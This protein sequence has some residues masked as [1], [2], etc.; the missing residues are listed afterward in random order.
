MKLTETNLRNIIRNLIKEISS[1]KAHK[2]V[3]NSANE[4]IEM[5]RTGSRL[6]FTNI[7]KKEFNRI[8]NLKNINNNYYSV[9][10]N[11]N[12]IEVFDSN[13]EYIKL[14]RDNINEII[15][16]LHKLFINDK[17]ELYIN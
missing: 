13:N 17:V 5:Q 7:P 10:I 4:L 1:H 6:K 16:Q 8:F 9:V 12:L 15:K 3:F 14:V 11:N 2:S